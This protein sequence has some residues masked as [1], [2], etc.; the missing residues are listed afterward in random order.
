MCIS[1]ICLLSD[2]QHDAGGNQ[3]GVDIFCVWYLYITVVLDPNTQFL[4]NKDEG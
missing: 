3:M 4:L 1:D 2:Q